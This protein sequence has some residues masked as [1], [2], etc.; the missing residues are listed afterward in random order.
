MASEDIE[1]IHDGCDTPSSRDP[2]LDS[3]SVYEFAA[4]SES[5]EVRGW[6]MKGLLHFE[7]HACASGCDEPSRP[8]QSTV[9]SRFACDFHQLL[10]FESSSRVSVGVDLA[11]GGSLLLGGTIPGPKAA[12][13]SKIK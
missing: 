4:M 12:S 9:S 5:T 1:K 2:I 3:S 8:I 7:V 11:E 10:S 6:A 13:K